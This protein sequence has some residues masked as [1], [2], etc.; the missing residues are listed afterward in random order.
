MK[1]EIGAKNCLYPM[2]TVLV[3]AMVNGKPNYATIAHVGIADFNS[4][5]ISMNKKHY[6]NAGIREN[7]CFSINVPTEDMVKI[8]DYCGI[9]SGKDED[10]SLLFKTFYGKLG[11]APMIEECPLCMECELIATVDFPNHDLFVG[12]VVGTY[13]DEHV[14]TDTNV[15]FLKLRPILF[16]MTDRSYYRLG[17]KLGKPWSIGKEFKK[18]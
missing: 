17:D 11:N 10:K 18:V 4:V 13:C 15:N 5:T 1:K 3:G 6:T 16:S 8:T 14:M 9:V 2:P 7:K 12:K